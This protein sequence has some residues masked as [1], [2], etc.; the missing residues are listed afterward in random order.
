MLRSPVVGRFIEKLCT[1]RK[2]HKS[3]GEA[4]RYPQLR[5]VGCAKVRGDPLAE[6]W[7]ALTQIDGYVE[8]LTVRDTHKL[9]L[10][11]FDLVVKATQYALD[12]A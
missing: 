11:L 4:L 6:C 2:D 3:V 8:H 9:A 7:R 10:S 1:F 5:P 12:G